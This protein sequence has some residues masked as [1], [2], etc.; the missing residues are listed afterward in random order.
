MRDIKTEKLILY[1]LNQIT[2]QYPRYTIAQHLSHILRRK[3]IGPEPYFWDDTVL[4]N[5][6]EAYL[7]ELHTD[8]SN[9]YIE[10]NGSIT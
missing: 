4:L 7:D 3:G 8:L 5:K 1:N 10:T 2:E 9:E 6:I